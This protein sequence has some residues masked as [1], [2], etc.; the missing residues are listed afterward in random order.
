MSAN[1]DTVVS[2]K[3]TSDRIKQYRYLKQRWGRVTPSVIWSFGI[4]LAL[5]KMSEVEGVP[6][7]VMKKAIIDGDDA[8]FEKKFLDMLELA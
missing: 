4:H 7:D 5:K 2:F 8:A 1:F 6:L 3:T